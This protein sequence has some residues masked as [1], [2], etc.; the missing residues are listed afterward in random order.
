[1]AHTPGGG[2]LAALWAEGVAVSSS[3]S[4]IPSSSLGLVQPSTV[5]GGDAT[6]P[7]P[8][9]GADGHGQ[10][11]HATPPAEGVDCGLFVPPV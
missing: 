2:G 4:D 9:P 3:S 11:G 6:P 1:M 8:R 5:A 10:G 7:G